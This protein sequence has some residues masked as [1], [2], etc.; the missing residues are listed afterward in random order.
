M[1]IL[2]AQKPLRGLGENLNLN[3]D[4]H[5]GVEDKHYRIWI[6]GIIIILL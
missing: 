2:D 5:C 1:F 4:K 3:A 6:V